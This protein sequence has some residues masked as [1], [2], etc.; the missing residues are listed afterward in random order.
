M[1]VFCE[2]TEY[3][4][5]KG[6]SFLMILNMLNSNKAV[7][8]SLFLG[9]FKVEVLYISLCDLRKKALINLITKRKQQKRT[10]EKGQ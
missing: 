2:C 3:I 8:R 7:V 9:F 1:L 6:I 5:G 4:S 10:R